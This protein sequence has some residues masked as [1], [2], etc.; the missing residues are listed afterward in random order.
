MQQELGVSEED[1]AVK[2]RA[3]DG[4]E[5]V[6]QLMPLCC[7]LQVA[8]RI[9]EGRIDRVR[10]QQEAPAEGPVPGDG[11]GAGAPPLQT[12]EQEVGLLGTNGDTPHCCLMSPS[13][14]FLC[15]QVA[16]QRKRFCQS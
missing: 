9:L 10:Q 12:P 8:I 15:L 5:A 16:R 7:G 11:P 6:C 14:C 4:R 3:S 13:L 1:C 2:L